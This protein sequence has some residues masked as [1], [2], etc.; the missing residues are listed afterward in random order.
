M[1]RLVYCLLCFIFGW[2]I[3][4]EPGRERKLHARELFISIEGYGPKQ[5][6][7]LWRR[8]G[9]MR[10][11]ELDRAR[12][13]KELIEENSKQTPANAMKALHFRATKNLSDGMAAS[14]RRLTVVNTLCRMELG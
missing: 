2:F 13:L 1:M 8:G 6:M 7:N 12:R 14:T 10:R 3:F 9:A 11:M 4:F 5:R